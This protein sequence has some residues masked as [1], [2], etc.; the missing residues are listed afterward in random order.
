MQYKVITYCEYS[1]LLIFGYKFISSDSLIILKL[2]HNVNVLGDKIENTANFYDEYCY[3]SYSSSSSINNILGC[4]DEQLGRG[5]KS[6]T[7][8]VV[9]LDNHTF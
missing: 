4:N 9:V 6:V 1:L 5:V 3:H 2:L 7:N 8:S